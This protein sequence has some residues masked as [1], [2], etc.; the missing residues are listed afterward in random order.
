M[1]LKIVVGQTRTYRAV[2]WAAENDRPANVSSSTVYTF[3]TLTILAIYC[4]WIVELTLTTGKVGHCSGI[5]T[6]KPFIHSQCV[7]VCAEEKTQNGGRYVDLEV[8]VRFSSLLFFFFLFNFF[9]FI[10]LFICMYT[11][12][13]YMAGRSWSNENTA[14]KYWCFPFGECCFIFHFIGM[15]TFTEMQSHIE[16]NRNRK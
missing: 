2:I 7:S 5:G 8:H 13:Y 14:I 15:V 9:N 1:G 11:N 16:S 3:N 12:P 10:Y 6:A 4:V